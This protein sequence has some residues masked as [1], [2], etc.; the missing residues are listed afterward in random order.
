MRI[1]EYLTL[2]AGAIGLAAILAGCGGVSNSDSI[3]QKVKNAP[4]VAKSQPVTHQT[5]QEA[6]K[7]KPLTE[8]RVAELMK[9]ETV[10]DIL[11]DVYKSGTVQQ[12]TYDGRRRRTN[13]DQLVFQRDKKTSER[14]PVMVMFYHNDDSKYSKN[15][16]TS[17]RE[18]ILFRQLALQY[19]DKIEFVAF[20]ADTDPTLVNSVKNRKRPYGIRTIPSIAMYSPWDIT[21]DETP[22]KNDGKVTQIDIL[23]GGPKKTKQ[24]VDWSTEFQDW[25]IN[26]NILNRPTPDD[27]GKL[28]QFNNTDNYQLV[29]GY[30]HRPKSK[31]QL[32]SR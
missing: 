4:Q 10:D 7:P 16:V 13:Y 20:E 29:K 28:Y 12:V 22:R 17:K 32:V 8:E 14:K 1:T 21:K 5:Q 3:D 23:R 15:K 30:S 26:P 18:A 11:A 19:R 9:K 24:V 2:T 25:W 31:D 6:P 27:D